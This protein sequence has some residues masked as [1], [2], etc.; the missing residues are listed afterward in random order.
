MEFEVRYAQG[1]PER[2]RGLV[3]DLLRLDVV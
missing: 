2:L 3:E 1:Q